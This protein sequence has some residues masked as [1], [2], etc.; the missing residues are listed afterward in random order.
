M[1]GNH[2]P[3]HNQ[4]SKDALIKD[5]IRHLKDLEEWYCR[6]TTVRKTW[7]A[8]GGIEKQTKVVF[9]HTEN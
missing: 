6:S 7:H 1:E 9:I 3:Q 2:L 5:S 4:F 8:G